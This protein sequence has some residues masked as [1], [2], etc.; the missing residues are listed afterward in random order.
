[1]F[2]GVP[3]AYS[4]LIIIS[5]LMSGRCMLRVEVSNLLMEND[6]DGDVTINNSNIHTLKNNIL[7]LEIR[8]TISA[9]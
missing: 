2:I 6:F 9:C 3:I 1:M 5:L 7:L 8:T 4:L